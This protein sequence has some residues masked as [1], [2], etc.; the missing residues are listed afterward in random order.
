MFKDYGALRLLEAW[1]D[2]VPD[3]VTDFRR[4][5]KAEPDEKAVRLPERLSRKSATL[6]TKR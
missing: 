3:K 4:A 6:R 2:D 1:G 5:V